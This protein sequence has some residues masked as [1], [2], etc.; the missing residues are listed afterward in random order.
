[1]T[2]RPTVGALGIVGSLRSGSWN[3]KLLHAAVALAP[4]DLKIDIWDEL[5]DIPPYNDDLEEDPPPVARLKAAIAERDAL[6]IASPEYNFGIP[7]VLKNALDWASMPPRQSVLG[8][9]TVAIMGA[10]PGMLGTARGQLQLRQAFIFTRTYPVLQPEVLVA[11][12]P[13]KFASDGTLADEL[14]QKLVRRL[15]ENLVR[16]TRQLATEV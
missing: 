3:R 6:V 11:M 13:E 9:K 12:A 16:L 10:S 4:D 8:G 2:A 1:M 14:A 5:G 15:L 7:G